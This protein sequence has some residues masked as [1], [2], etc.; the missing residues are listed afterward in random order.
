MDKEF[1]TH[2]ASFCRN[3]SSIYCSSLCWRYWDGWRSWSSSECQRLVW[4]HKCVHPYHY[5]TEFW[6]CWYWF[7]V[8]VFLAQKHFL[9]LSILYI[10]LNIR[11]NE[12]QLPIYLLYYSWSYGNS[13]ALNKRLNID[14]SQILLFFCHCH[15]VKSHKLFK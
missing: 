15:S 12:K 13:I 2:R 1:F 10:D 5:Q 6:I 7:C 9:W 8:A 11:D 14:P 3:T 4:F